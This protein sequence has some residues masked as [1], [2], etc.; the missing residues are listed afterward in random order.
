MINSKQEEFLKLY[1]PIH[2]RFERFCR[3]RV[4]GDMEFRDLMNE[5]L[6]VA[7]EKFET[8]KSSQAFLS[9]LFSI[10]VRIL[11]NQNRKKSEVRLEIDGSILKKQD[12]HAQTDLEV[13]IYF[14]YESLAKLGDDQRE[15]L[16][17][18]E[19]SG[20]S[21]KEIAEIQ[22][23]SES[24]VKQRLKRGR[25]KLTEILTFESELKTGEVQHG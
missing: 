25:E 5:T 7:Y 16:I 2:D 24:A 12:N 17:L 13:E 11:A 19:I 8:L 3:A 10:S 1:E 15:S 14:L 23:A 21:I 4:Y 9:F 18:F 20:F 6:L 22:N